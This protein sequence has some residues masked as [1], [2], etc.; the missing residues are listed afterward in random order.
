MK[1]A[2]K[3]IYLIDP[4]TRDY[5]FDP[6]LCEDPAYDSYIRYSTNKQSKYDVKYHKTMTK[7]ERIVTISVIVLGVLLATFAGVISGVEY[8]KKQQ[9]EVLK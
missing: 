5:C 7:A 4:G 8:Q 9:I 6:G 1:N 3:I 2:P